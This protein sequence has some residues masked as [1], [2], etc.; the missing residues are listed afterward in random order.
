MR[1]LCV[2]VYGNAA[3]AT[4]LSAARLRVVLRHKEVSEVQLVR[5]PVLRS[6]EA[7]KVW[8]CGRAH[9][10]F[11]FSATREP[12]E[13]EVDG[14][15]APVQRAPTMLSRVRIGLTD[16]GVTRRGGEQPEHV[17]RCR[18]VPRERKQML[19][20]TGVPRSYKVCIANEK[21]RLFS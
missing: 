17:M 9:V 10:A 16:D 7:R 5:R 21:Y 4:F 8:E 1:A 2:V 19:L 14:G 13:W 15:I 6:K 18:Q 11:D 3:S 20:Q 12:G